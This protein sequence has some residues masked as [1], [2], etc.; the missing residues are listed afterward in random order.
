MAEP[1]FRYQVHPAT[2]AYSVDAHRRSIVRLTVTARNEGAEA[3]ACRRITIRVPSDQVTKPTTLT[4]DPTTITVSVGDA[5]PWAITTSGDGVCYAVPLPPA[6]G[7]GPGATAD[8]VLAN[9]V[10]NTMPGPVA[11]AIDETVGQVTAST[12]VTV[13]K[14][15]PVGPGGD[16]PVVTSFTATPT[17]I[18]LGG[19]ATIAWKV[20]GADTCTLSPGP[21]TLPSPVSGTLDVPVLRTTIFTIEALAVAGTATATAQVTV[22][23]V[24]IDDFRADPPGAVPKGGPVTLRWATRFASSCTIDQGV[25][26]VPTSGDCVVTPMQTTVYTLAAGGLQPRAR[27]VTVEVAP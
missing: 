18:A 24:A 14:D 16:P 21:V 15:T 11:I 1:R 13:R 9:V 25:G 3:V 23:P 27:I 5:T 10:V 6:T 20:T 26:D 4:A 19:R 8:L 2:V 22:M 12:S 17:E 7:I